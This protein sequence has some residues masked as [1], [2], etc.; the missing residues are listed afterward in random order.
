VRNFNAIGAAEQSESGSGRVDSCFAL[1]NLRRYSLL[2]VKRVTSASAD[3]HSL[4]TRAGSWAGMLNVAVTKSTVDASA[5]YARPG[6]GWIRPDNSECDQ[7]YRL[8]LKCSIQKIIKIPAC[9]P[10]DNVPHCVIVYLFFLA[11]I[12]IMPGLTNLC[13]YYIISSLC[14]P[15]ASICTSLRSMK[16]MP[17]RDENCNLFCH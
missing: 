12:N 11:H 9:R 14:K 4:L 6:N 7:P 10:S 1:V 16:C 5:D 3:R 13:V 17:E 2:S 15:P 8:V